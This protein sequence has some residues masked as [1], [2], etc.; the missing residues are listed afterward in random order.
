[1]AKVI[2]LVLA[3]LILAP[4]ASWTQVTSRPVPQTLEA[5]QRMIDAAGARWIAGRTA[6]S[7]M[8]SEEGR[9]TC[10]CYDVP[11]PGDLP[12]AERRDLP[13]RELPAEFDWRSHDGYDWTTPV[14]NQGGC[15]SCWAFCTL[16]VLEAEVKITEDRPRLAIDLSEQYFMS[17]SEQGCNQ[18]SLDECIDW[19]E[20]NG[21]PDEYCMG[22]EA[23]GAPDCSD[24]CHDAERHLLTRKNDGWV[25]EPP[26]AQ[27]VDVIKQ[28]VL[29]G[30][31]ATIM[32]VFEDFYYDYATGVYEQ[33]YGQ[34]L[35]NHGVIIIGWSDS[36]QYWICKNSYGTGWGMDGYFHIA[37]GQNENKIEEGSVW[38][39]PKLCYVLE[40]TS[41]APQNVGSVSS[42]RH[43]HAQVRVG[44][45]NGLYH[46]LDAGDFHATVGSWEADVL[47]VVERLKHYELTIAPPDESDGVTPTMC[48]NLEVS[49]TCPAFSETDCVLGAVIYTDAE[50]IPIDVVTV[51]DRSGSMVTSEYLQPALDAAE[52]FVGF[53][54][55][56]DMVGVVSFSGGASVEFPLTLIT[57]QDV[58]YDAQDE[59]Q[60]VVGGGATSIAA[61]LLAAESQFA[62]YGEPTDPWATVL[63]SDG[64]ETQ[65]PWVSDMLGD[66]S[67]KNDVYTI[68][69]GENS[70]EALLEL[71]A[72]YTGGQF[73]MTPTP[74]QL[75]AI[76]S[77][78]RGQVSRDQIV[79][80]GSGQVSQNELSGA[81]TWVDDT[82]TDA[83][84]L[85]GWT[86]GDLDLTLE[87]PSGQVVDSQAA[88]SDTGITY[89]E[90]DRYE[91][92]T[93]QEPLS[94]QWQ[95]QVYGENVAGSAETYGL[96]V[97]ADTELRLDADF[98]CDDYTANQTIGI[99]AALLEGDDPIVNAE[100]TATVHPPSVGRSA[101][102]TVMGDLAPSASLRTARDTICLHLYDD[103]G[104][105]DGVARDGVY[106]NSFLG[107]I[108][109]GT[110]VFDL[111]AIGST[112]AGRTFQRVTQRATNVGASSG[113]GVISGEVSYT[114]TSE[115]DLYVRAWRNDPYMGGMPEYVAL[116]AEADF[117]QTY[118]LG[119]LPDGSYYMDAFLDMAGNAGWNEDEE[120]QGV[121]GTP[122][123]VSVRLGVTVE[124][125][126]FDLQDQSYPEHCIVYPNP[127]R[128]GADGHTEVVFKGLRRG[129]TVRIYTL[130]GDLVH[131]SG[132]SVGRQSAWNAR[133]EDGE[134]VA[135]GVYYYVVTQPGAETQS[136][137]L[138]IIRE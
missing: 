75:Q 44:S 58:I 38:I 109:E 126:D 61:G 91:Y 120:P 134:R 105:G 51:I 73:Y 83:V 74:D 6:N 15:E 64:Y 36:G 86:S 50:E 25:G 5:K 68:A 12:L 66:L 55:T 130:R 110:Y 138:A 106:G 24:A 67:E 101:W 128:E 89:V 121:F 45:Y 95:L 23:S 135:R 8:S 27:P 96:T 111:Q 1:M 84:F 10:G 133:N 54:H 21:V 53:M 33:V 59:I 108:G 118:Q 79:A 18:W 94:G 137:K 69:L 65:A 80:L 17:C 98:Y 115:G 7:D 82:M 31:V 113:T 41:S 125:I 71:I 52:L 78:I 9:R 48:Y 60:S 47:Q 26:G 2:W 37:M 123:S 97:T 16:G 102:T 3:V 104:H 87:D 28:N 119:P 100:I 4:S 132:P 92:F 13:W 63:L 56:N 85:I 49:V 11:P 19:L 124:D 112:A 43:V 90:E 107:A 72:N 57:S 127:F 81:A 70:D 34:Y 22:Y 30:P 29:E 39:E 93:V 114:G 76:Y 40:P 14:K 32:A 35:G 42:P 117:P 62:E 131:E 46:G 20:E 77:L 122:D 88:A 116:V 99:L 103:G 129:S 136:G